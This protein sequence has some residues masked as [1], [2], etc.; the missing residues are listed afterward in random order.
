MPP[1]PRYVGM[2]DSAETPAPADTPTPDVAAVM[3]RFQCA[4]CH[5]IDGAESADDL[6]PPLNRVATGGHPAVGDLF[7]REFFRRKVGD[8]RKYWDGT[9]MN[10]TPIRL[11]P[12][13]EELAALEAW[14]FDR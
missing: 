5:R 9:S 11:R 14:F 12:A 7:T 1:L 6:G 2:T 10:Y 8:P 3:E 4:R 13:P